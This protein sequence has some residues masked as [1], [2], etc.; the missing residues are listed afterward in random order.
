M[1]NNEIP[2]ILSTEK[3]AL[4]QFL[5]EYIKPGEMISVDANWLQS[6]LQELNKLQRREIQ[7]KEIESQNERK[8]IIL[9]RKIDSMNTALDVIKLKTKPQI[10]KNRVLDINI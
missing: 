6:K 7:Q 1:E 5:C 2:V 8:L 10:V 4:D 9:K 3:I